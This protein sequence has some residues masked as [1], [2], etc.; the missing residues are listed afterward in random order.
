[1]LYLLYLLYLLFSK[2]IDEME[3]NVV[4]QNVPS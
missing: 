3:K 1:M 4:F 2:Y